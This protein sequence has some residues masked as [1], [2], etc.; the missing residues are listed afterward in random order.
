MHTV[1]KIT[2]YRS[3]IDREKLKKLTKKS[4]IQG[5]TRAG[6]VLILYLLT[7][8]AALLFFLQEMW[9]AMILAAYIHSIFLGFLGTGAAVHELSHS[10]PFK[11][12]LL[13]TLFIHIFA[14]LTWSSP[15]HFIESHR[16]H[17]QYTGFDDLDKEIKPEPISFTKVQVLGWFLF[18]WANFKRIMNT[19]IQLAAGNANADFFS[20]NPL[21][22]E[23][24]PKRKTLL[25]WSRFMITGHLLL[26]ALFSY[27]GLWILIYT[28]SFGYFFASFLVHGCEIQQHSGFS[29]NVPDWRII[30]ST[31]KFG[32]FISFFYW[33]MNYHCEHHMYAAVPFYNLPKL[34]K[35]LEADLAHPLPGYIQGLKNII[36]TKNLQQTDPDYR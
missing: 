25:R 32:R 1:P 19:H 2:W 16:R 3:P 22:E 23:D 27:F 24:N 28:V 15:V 5:L 36:R 26:I 8:A 35:E 17:H 31:A 6:S 21:F 34:H 30:A 18:D 29:R 20:W 13:N 11:S 9:W 14:F 7:T 10:T 4:N 12:K 33:N